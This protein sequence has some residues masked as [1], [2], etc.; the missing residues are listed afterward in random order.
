MCCTWPPTQRTRNEHPPHQPHAVHHTR[1]KIDSG[2]APS[3]SSSWPRKKTTA[4]T[5]NCQH[6]LQKVHPY[7]PQCASC[8]CACRNT[9]HKSRKEEAEYVE[10]R[11]KIKCTAEVHGGNNKKKTA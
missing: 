1:R 5:R 2:C 4:A 7:P 11:T 9:K 8:V 10:K 3:P 6:A